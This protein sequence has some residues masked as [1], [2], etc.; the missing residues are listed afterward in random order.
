MAFQFP[1]FTRR[2]HMD[3]ETASELDI[4]VGAH[5]YAARHS[6]RILMLGWSVDD[7]HVNMWQPHLE[8]TPPDELVQLLQDPTVCKIAFNA[9][10]ERLITWHCMGIEVPIEQ[11]RCTMV[12]AY[13]LGF[14][15]GLDNILKAIGLEQKDSKGKQLIN[16]FCKPAPKN[17]KASHYDWTNKPVEWQLFVGYCIQDVKVERQLLHFLS[18][19][20][21]MH[22]WDWTQWFVDQQINDRGVLMDLDM[23]YAAIE[24]WDVEKKALTDDLA[25]ATRLV[26]VTRD[27]FKQWMVD[28]FGFELE[29]L[30]KDY[31]ESL[32]H[33]KQLPP[34]AE[35]FIKLWAQ[36]EGKAVS[37]YTAVINSSCDDDRARGLF[38]YK[39]ASRTDRAGGRRIQLQN[40]KRAFVDAGQH[41]IDLLVSA[42]KTKATKLLSWMYSMSVSEILGGSIRHVIMAPEGKTFAV[43]DLT[44][45]ES[46]VLG[47]VTQCKTVD[48]TFREGKDTYKQFASN[49]Y[50][51]PYDDVTKA[52]R[53]FS[54]PPVLGC[55][56]MLGAKGLIA[57]AEGYG[58]DMT[59]EQ[60]K[61]AVDTFR[62][63]YPE[64][65]AFWKWVYDSVMAVTQS[66]QTIEGYNLRIERDQDFVRIWLPSGRAI[67]YYHPEVRERE[68]PWRNLTPKAEAAA[69]GLEYEGWI[70]AGWTDHR[71]L[72]EGYMRPIQIIKNFCYMGQNDKNQWVRCFAHA[73]LITENIVQ[74][75]AGDFLWNGIMRATA[76]GLPVVI[77][78]HDEIVAEVPVETAGRDL[79]TLERCMTAAPD[80][81][82]DMWLGADGY[83]LNRYTKD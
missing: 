77:H 76:E 66:Y 50:G 83:I 82:P 16:T 61:N 56:F 20:P 17:H 78:V 62:N 75:I 68:A 39:G 70:A 49:Y 27:P 28:T 55:G 47:W 1:G 7:G 46:V 69:P 4:K 14:A 74:S 41:N 10:F 42:I 24:M 21:M 65:V 5:K 8:P 52:Q 58:V 37:K 29:N 19:F 60:A 45:I 36:K 43:C 25:E 13:Y 71:L 23:S 15:G 40:L 33:K 32:L 64:I 51:I 81:A 38:Q 80:W 72:E 59:K 22:G 12:A 54:K 73:G 48:D 9:Q 18:R 11:W 34:E 26:K 44:S 3:Y 79:E 2:L 6:T 63:M 31:L 67:S 35:P 57:Y 30:R 53:T